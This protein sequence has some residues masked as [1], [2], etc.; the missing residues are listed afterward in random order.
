M[1][2]NELLQEQSAEQAREHAHR[3]EEARPAGDPLGAVEREP[4]P[5]HDHVHV[6]MMGERRAPGMKNGQDTDACSEVL[7]VGCDRDQRLGRRLEQDAVDRGLVHRLLRL[8]PV[9]AYEIDQSFFNEFT[10]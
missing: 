6:R 9:T 4:T 1:S 2:G 7:G 10:E 8:K 3:E 5:R